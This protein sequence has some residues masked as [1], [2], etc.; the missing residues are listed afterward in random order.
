MA[1]GSVFSCARMTSTVSPVRLIT[2]T[3]S[4]LAGKAADPVG[5]TMQLNGGVGKLTP[6]PA[7]STKVVP[8]LGGFGAV[9]TT[10]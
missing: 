6:L 2:R 4:A 1:R 3:I 7:E 10:E 5:Q 9:A 8:V